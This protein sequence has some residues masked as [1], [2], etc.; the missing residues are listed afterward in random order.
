[1]H[2]Q[3]EKNIWVDIFN[4][5]KNHPKSQPFVDKVIG[6]NNDQGDIFIRFH[7]I[8]KNDVKGKRVELIEIGPR[9]QL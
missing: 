5:G 1:M 2:K 7:Q 4:V 8:K 9:I 6:F 3:L